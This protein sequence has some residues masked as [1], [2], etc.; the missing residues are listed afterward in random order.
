MCPVVVIRGKHIFS[1]CLQRDCNR[2]QY[3]NPNPT[4][5]GENMDE[6]KIAV[7][8]DEESCRKMLVDYLTKYSR[9][10]LGGGGEL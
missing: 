1:A 9:E 3:F 5:K 2:K 6:L 8:E 7:V 10:E 4:H